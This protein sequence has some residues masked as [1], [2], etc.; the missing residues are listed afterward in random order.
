M[1]YEQLFYLMKFRTGDEAITIIQ[2]QLNKDVKRKD[3][4]KVIAF[5][6]EQKALIEKKKA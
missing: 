6:E 3:D 5:V 1:L 2:K 4:P